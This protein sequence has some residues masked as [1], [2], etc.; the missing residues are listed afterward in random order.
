MDFL[1]PS[2]NSAI[3]GV[4]AIILFSQYFLRRS[5]VGLAKTPPIPEGAWPI[6]GHL[7]LLGGTKPPYR[8]LGAMADKHGPAFTIQLGFHRALVVS[9]WEMAKECFTTND[10][11]VS[12]RPQLV[13]AKHMGYNSAVFGFA[14]SM[15]SYVRVSE[16]E[17]SLK[18]LYTLWTKR[19]NE[20]GQIL[21]EM[22]QW[23]ADLTLNVILRMIAGK[24][25]YG[26]HSDA[27]DKEVARRCQKALEEFLRYT[28]L[29]VVSDAIPCLGWL[30]IGGHEK[31]MKKVAK[32]FDTIL[33]EWLEEHK[34][35]RASGEAKGPQDFMD[36]M[37]S[38]LDGKD[39]EGFDADTVN[40][41]TS[42]VRIPFSLL[43]FNCASS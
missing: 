24:R 28:G 13:A 1:S 12:S 31:A 27:G 30:D 8:T 38:V 29:F 42:M 9:S 34:Q 32:E 41:A 33:E 21:V 26:D 15:L 18:E 40:K 23:F 22:K 5:K 11:A 4:I 6:I 43:G 25:Y 10:L 16:V 3:V 14:P 36:V 17:T 20:S 7:P 39:L 35:K 19:K 37:L 2:L